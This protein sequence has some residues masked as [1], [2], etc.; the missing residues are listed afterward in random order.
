MAALWE[1]YVKSRTL[2]ALNSKNSDELFHN[3]VDDHIFAS[4]PITVVDGIATLHTRGDDM[5]R[6]KLVVAH[7]SFAGS[8]IEALGAHEVQNW[9]NWFVSQG[10]LVF[11]LR[12]KRTIPPEHKLWATYEKVEGTASQIVTI[13]VNLLMVRHQ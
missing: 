2:S 4:A 3:E 10:P 7:E 6:V 11:R 1:S 12:S 13:G 9:Y 5:M 8:D